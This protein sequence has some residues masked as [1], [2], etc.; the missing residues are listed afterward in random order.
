M[1]DPLAIAP[2]PSRRDPSERFWEKV[3]KSGECWIWLGSKNSKGYG[4]FMYEKPK[5]VGAHRFAYEDQVGPIPEG[6]TID[7]LCWNPSCVRPSHLEPVTQAENNRRERERLRG[8][9]D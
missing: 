8:R 1:G 2:P 5:R 4:T 6:L 3:D 7:H 9:D